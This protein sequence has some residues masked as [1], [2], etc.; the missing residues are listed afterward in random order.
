MN[1]SAMI[2]NMKAKSR[3]RQDKRSLAASSNLAKLREDRLR[4]EG[5]AK[6]LD[7][8][9]EEKARISSAKKYIRKERFKQSVAGRVAVKL[10]DGAKK[11][12]EV[13]KDSKKKGNPFLPSGKD[14][15]MFK[16]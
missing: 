7:L 5:Q 12:K 16:K 4:A 1:I 9:S 6:V 10:G 8:Q 13:S 2:N 15:P 14:H 3:A 11:L